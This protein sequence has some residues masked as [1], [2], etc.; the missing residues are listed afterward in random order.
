MKYTKYKFVIEGEGNLYMDS[1]TSV[2]AQR[3]EE[4]MHRL[5]EVSSD[6]RVT[7][8]DVAKIGEEEK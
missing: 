7:R 3:L 8:I 5:T 4:H 2:L 6:T 1:Y